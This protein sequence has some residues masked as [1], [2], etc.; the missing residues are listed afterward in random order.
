MVYGHCFGFSIWGHRYQYKWPKSIWFGRCSEHNA[1]NIFSLNAF[2]LWCTRIMHTSKFLQITIEINFSVI[3]L[4]GS[5]VEPVVELFFNE[6]RLKWTKRRGM[7]KM[8]CCWFNPQT[9][10]T[11]SVSKADSLTNATIERCSFTR[12]QFTCKRI[13]YFWIWYWRNSNSCS[14]HEQ[15]SER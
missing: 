15:F 3:S 12:T 4:S 14:H 6:L 2:T 13:W 11:S 1:L 5:R 7:H 10:E 8:E 9:H